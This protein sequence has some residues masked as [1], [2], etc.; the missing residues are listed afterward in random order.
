MLS[1]RDQEPEPENP[2]SGLIVSMRLSF[3]TRVKRATAVMNA[4]SPSDFTQV[5]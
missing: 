3:R 2:D 4:D 5:S 1:G